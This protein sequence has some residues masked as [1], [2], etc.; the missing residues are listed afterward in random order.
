MTILL[1]YEIGHA[2]CVRMVVGMQGPVLDFDVSSL[3]NRAQWDISD[4]LKVPNISIGL[5]KFKKGLLSFVKGVDTASEPYF[6]HNRYFE[7]KK[8]RSKLI[9]LTI[10][11][12]LSVSVDVEPLPS[13]L[14]GVLFK[15][16][17]SDM[18]FV[19]LRRPHWS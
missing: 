19:C 12:A 2:P 17:S 9:R 5:V 14:A 7:N 16:P 4:L 18:G 6:F 15:I 8:G 3:C 1:A 10:P 13:Q 11:K